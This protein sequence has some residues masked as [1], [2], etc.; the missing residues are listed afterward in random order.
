MNV[1]VHVTLLHCIYVVQETCKIL[2]MI[3]SYVTCTVYKYMYVCVHEQ[4]CIH[5]FIVT[6]SD[7]LRR[8]FYVLTLYT[9]MTLSFSLSLSPSSLPPPFHFPVNS[10]GVKHFEKER[11]KKNNH[12]ASKLVKSVYPVSMVTKI[13]NMILRYWLV[14]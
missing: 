12:N 6:S 11:Q 9:S 8:K 4:L 3:Q 5:L 1:H 14:Y 2:S 13:I 7:I 10:M